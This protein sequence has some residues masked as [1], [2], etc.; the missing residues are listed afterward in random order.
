LKISQ[1]SSSRLPLKT[2]QK[3]TV[4]IIKIDNDDGKRKPEKNICACDQYFV[5]ISGGKDE[6][7]S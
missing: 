3:I 4:D 5:M 1:L 7:R 6:E 2:Q